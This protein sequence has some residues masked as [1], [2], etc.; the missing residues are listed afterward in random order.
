MIDYCMNEI[1][2]ED[3][4]EMRKWRGFAKSCDLVGIDN[5]NDKDDKNCTTKKSWQMSRM[6]AWV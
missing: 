2:G 4:V 3:D 5:D 6:Q 1:D